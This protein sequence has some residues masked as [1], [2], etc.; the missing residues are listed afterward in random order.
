MESTNTLNSTLNN[1]AIDVEQAQYEAA[2][3]ATCSHCKKT[4]EN[5]YWT[6]NGLM[7]CAACGPLFQRSMDSAR[8]RKNFL[9]T[10]VRAGLVALLCGAGYAV[11]VGVT[12]YELALITIAIGH[13][14]ATTVQKRT[15]GFA[16]RRHQILAVVLTYIACSMGAIAPIGRAV[17][18][19]PP[20]QDVPSAQTQ[21]T[22]ENTGHSAATG[23]VESPPRPPVQT[24][25]PP[26]AAVPPEPPPS[27][28]QGLLALFT[29]AVLFMGLCLISPFLALTTGAQGIISVAI[30]GFAL[31]TAWKKSKG[32]D[33]KLLGPFALQQT[34]LAEAPEP[35]QQVAESSG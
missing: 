34:T 31:H 30:V 23:Q 26:S 20:Q 18:S 5:E 8:S 35:A 9:S 14:V 33:Y 10:S 22:S 16:Q 12:H 25:T 13:F 24:V 29:L 27:L 6:G 4:V 7:L 3:I 21:T 11:F 32:V 19:R 17:W 28:A 15:L 1:Q 2:P